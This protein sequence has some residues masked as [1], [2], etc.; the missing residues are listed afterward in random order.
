MTLGSQLVV[1]IVSSSPSMYTSFSWSSR[2]TA[3]SRKNGRSRTETLY[4]EPV[5]GPVTELAH[6]LAGF[7][8]VILDIGVIAGQRLQH[9]R[10]HTPQAFWR[11][12]HGPADVALPFGDDVDERR[13]VQTERHRLPQIRFVEGRHIPVD[14][15]AAADAERH[16]LADRL[17]HLALQV[18]EQRHL[19]AIEEGHIKL[20]GNKCQRRGRLVAYDRIFDAIEIRP[21]RFP[22]IRVSRHPYPFVRLEFDE[23]EWAGAD[24]S[25]A[26]VARLDVAGIDR[27]IP[28]GE[29]RKKARLWP[30][31]MEGNFVIATGGDC[32]EVPPPGFA[33]ID[34]ELLARFP[35]QQVKGA[36]DVLGRERFAVVPADPCAQRQGQLGPVLVP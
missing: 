11:G 13:T 4:L 30:L 27:R 31:Q 22:V 14:D 35:G 3:G 18:P 10:R 23:F 12:L 20:P 29:S 7:R 1:S 32:F 26:H 21:A 24:R 28:T 33:R 25:L 8:A 36:L 34:P 5:S 19:E 2:I 9:L 15:Q 16:Q 6:E 17:R